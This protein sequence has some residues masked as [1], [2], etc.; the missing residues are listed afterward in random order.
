LIKKRANINT[1][2]ATGETALHMVLKNANSC[3]SNILLKYGAD[4][5]ARNAQGESPLHVA[6]ESH[7][8][9]SLCR[10]LIARGAL[11][12]ALDK[13]RWSPL[14]SAAFHSLRDLGEM[15]E[16]LME[17][18]A[19]ISARDIH[20]KTPLQ[21]VTTVGGS[22]EIYRHFVDHAARFDAESLS[23]VSKILK[24]QP[25]CEAFFIPKPKLYDIEIF[26][27]G[28]FV[29][30]SK[31]NKK[32]FT[33]P[34]AILNVAAYEKIGEN[35][36][37]IARSFLKTFDPFYLEMAKKYTL[38]RILVDD[39]NRL[40]TITQ[41]VQ[42]SFPKLP[43]GHWALNGHGDEGAVGIGKNRLFT[44]TQTRLMQEISSYVHE[45]G[46]IALWGC[47]NAEGDSNIVQEFSKNAKQ[48]VFGCP[49]EVLCDPGPSVMVWSSKRGGPPLVIP[50]LT[51]A[52]EFQAIRAYKNGELIADSRCSMRSSL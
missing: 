8:S 14:H 38:A 46:S 10:D 1:K 35:F 20:G 43:I 5:N 25:S 48:I 36:G 33:K 50:F 44:S 2:N 9:V 21:I 45:N 19:D 4:I 15:C 47:L 42:Q 31:I 7:C 12:N 17:K 28:K 26:F 40:V 34:I 49:Q 37:A 6:I 39:P 18:G 27:N 22:L 24:S 51:I 11:I 23:A 29:S 13:N 30:L 16:L 3:L 41:N 52:P 32:L